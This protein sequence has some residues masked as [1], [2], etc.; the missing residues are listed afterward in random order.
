MG[1]KVCFVCSARLLD[2]LPSYFPQKHC[3]PGSYGSDM[4]AVEQVAVVHPEFC[5]GTILLQEG[6]LTVLGGQVSEADVFHS[7]HS[8]VCMGWLPTLLQV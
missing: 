2:L 3:Q 8:H 5:R 1:I 6:D 4:R 7:R